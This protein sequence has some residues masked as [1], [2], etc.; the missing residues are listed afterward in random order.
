MLA[1]GMISSCVQHR[2]TQFE[3]FSN[4][5]IGY[6]DAI[7]VLTEVA[8]NEAIDADSIILIK[9][10][11][12]V[13]KTE[14]SA[15]Y[16]KHTEALNSLLSEL[17]KFREHSGLLKK[18]F[19][20]LGKLAI[21][22]A[23]SGIA[24]NTGTLIDGL[25]SL[26]PSLKATTIGTAP[27]K[28]FITQPTELTVSIFKHKSLEKELKK[29]A[30][31]IERELDL[32]Q[33]FLSALAIDLKNDLEVV[34]NSKNYNE[35]AKPYIADGK[36]PKNWAENR[37]EVI[38]AYLMIGSVNNAKIAAQELKEVFVALVEKKIEPG[39]FSVLFEDINAM[40]DIVELAKKT[41]I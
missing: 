37:R 11:D 28:D 35:V 10:R 23:P 13:S 21:S 18:Y 34:L 1:A 27:V 36:L 29:N 6:S 17:S 25:Q 5:G 40:L 39:D 41:T 12:S 3:N 31:T 9:N 26:S 22:N 19:N 20:T 15:R 33:A 32:Q 7:L 24:E 14:R 16:L 38:S 30:K 4:A 2:L 8:G